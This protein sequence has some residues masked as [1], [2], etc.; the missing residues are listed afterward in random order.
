MK[1]PF[2]ENEDK[3]SNRDETRK[4]VKGR[5]GG[6][7]DYLIGRPELDR[8]D[9]RIPEDPVARI[10]EPEIPVGIP[11]PIQDPKNRLQEFME[12]T[13]GKSA[14]GN[15]MRMTRNEV[16]GNLA[17]MLN[18]GYSMYAGSKWWNNSKKFF[19][20]SKEIGDIVDK[21]ASEQGIGAPSFRFG[22]EDGPMNEV[23]A[24]YEFNIAGDRFYVI[25]FRSQGS[26]NYAKAHD[27]KK[28]DIAPAVMVDIIADC[29]VVY[30]MRTGKVIDYHVE[31]SINRHGGPILG[32]PMPAVKEE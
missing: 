7:I 3:E 20:K 6:L 14:Y 10:P 29:K 2:F 8:S 22:N 9:V 26:M 12:S 17:L 30:D 5:F 27:K 21:F 1:K 28:G 4:E 15:Y 24:A 16:P 31:K 11:C 13:G 18:W 19:E 25:E 23:K 32:A